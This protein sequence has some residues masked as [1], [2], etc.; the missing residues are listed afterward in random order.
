MTRLHLH[1]LE[2]KVKTMDDIRNR[3]TGFVMGVVFILLV[4]V[5]IALLW[6]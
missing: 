1:D 5:G 3:A 6:E 2:Q 4:E